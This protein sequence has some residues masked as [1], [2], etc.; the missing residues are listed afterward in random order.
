[1]WCF[2]NGIVRV[3]R[4]DAFESKK[5]GHRVSSDKI[6]WIR[7]TRT[8]VSKH[9]QSEITYLFASPFP[10]DKYTNS[11][12]KF[13]KDEDDK[14]RIDP[15]VFRQLWDR[16]CIEVDNLPPPDLQNQI[17]PIFAHT[18]FPDLA[19]AEYTS[20]TNAVTLASR[21]ITDPKYL[22]FWVKLSAGR[23]K[24]KRDAAGNETKEYYLADPTDNSAGSVTENILRTATALQRI[25]PRIKFFNMDQTYS[26]AD[27]H[28]VAETFMT[29]DDYTCRRHEV[30]NVGESCKTCRYCR[31]DD[32]GICSVCA[33][34]KYRRFTSPEL[35]DVQKTRDI[36][37][38]SRIT[39]IAAVRAVLEA[40]DDAAGTLAP[41]RPVRAALIPGRFAP[42]K[43]GLHWDM[44]TSLR[45]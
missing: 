19:D 15:T 16:S 17:H 45:D 7:A 42:I 8:S 40:E 20:I 30:L 22:D 1:M 32:R 39:S 4:I 31:A 29:P 34:R 5:I 24:R 37:G 25:A 21:F 23:P 14:C 9:I 3:A 43:I 38:R 44:I 26:E 10:D 12:I 13:I 33:C 27:E 2:D 41:T 6:A 11:A 35:Q 18:N 28:R 36:A